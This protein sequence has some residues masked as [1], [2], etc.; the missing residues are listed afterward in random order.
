MSRS[1]PVDCEATPAP[2]TGSPKLPDSPSLLAGKTSMRRRAV[3]PLNMTPCRLALGYLHLIESL[4]QTPRELAGVVIGPEVHEEQPR[5]IVE[6]VVV[7]GC[8]LD[9]VPAERLEHRVHLVGGQHEVARDRSL[10]AAGR[11]EVDR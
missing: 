8:H 6:H 2:M 9:A 10:A 1:H 4:T 7:H 5:L 11:L 3:E